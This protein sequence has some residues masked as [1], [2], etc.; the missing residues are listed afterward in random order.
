MNV[1]TEAAIKGGLS[2][3]GP[4]LWLQGG[5]SNTYHLHLRP[6]EALV[7]EFG[8]LHGFMDWK[9]PYLPTAAAFRY[10]PLL[11]LEKLRRRAYI[12]KPSG[13]QE[14]IHVAGG[15]HEVGPLWAPTSQ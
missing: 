2:S 6:G 8:G 3:E 9:D 12:S 5:L 11:S 7:K 15:Q 10:I 14:D 13:R 1:G 4:W